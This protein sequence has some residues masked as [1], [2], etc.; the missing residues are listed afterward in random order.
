MHL[1]LTRTYLL[2]EH[3]N[4]TS[5]FPEKMFIVV[6]FVKKILILKIINLQTLVLTSLIVKKLNYMYSLAK[7]DNS[8]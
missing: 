6:S 3:D 7:T 5:P 1:L 2:I 8:P 4:L